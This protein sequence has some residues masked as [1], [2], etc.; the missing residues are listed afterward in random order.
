M[1]V[2]RQPILP[3]EPAPDYRLEKGALAVAAALLA[4][5]AV[6]MSLEGGSR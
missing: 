1:T 2:R 6:A 3:P 5:L 4:V